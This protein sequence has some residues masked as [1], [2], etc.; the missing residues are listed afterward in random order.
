MVEAMIDIAERIIALQ[1]GSPVA[2]SAEAIERLKDYGVI[3]EADVYTKMVRFRNFLVHHYDVL[4]LGI[5]YQIITVHLS[6]FE[7]FKQ[8]ILEYV[9]A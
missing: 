7:Q 1:G 6:D 5:M 8:E 2:G 4:D 9:N 3:R